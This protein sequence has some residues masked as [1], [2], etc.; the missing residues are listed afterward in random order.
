MAENGSIET[1]SKVI[2]VVI[3]DVRKSF[4]E[5]GMDL[6]TLAKL[7]K[8]WI[9]KLRTVEL[10]DSDSTSNLP[11]EPE[12]VG[13]KGNSS[14]LKVFVE[15]FYAAAIIDAKEQMNEDATDGDIDDE[16]DGDY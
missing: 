4:L 9:S 10:D 6:E 13:R 1:D 12:S 5:S 14:L 11:R 15:N 3:D 7:E 8:L 16:D 2:S